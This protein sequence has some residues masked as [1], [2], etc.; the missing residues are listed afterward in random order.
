MSSDG[1]WIYVILTMGMF[2]TMSMLNDS[3]KG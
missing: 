3:S 2:L 1:L